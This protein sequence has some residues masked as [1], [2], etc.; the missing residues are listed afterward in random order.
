MSAFVSRWFTYQPPTLIVANSFNSDISIP[1]S[2]TLY[3]LDESA[4]NEILIYI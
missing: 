1:V 2:L 3:S 4:I